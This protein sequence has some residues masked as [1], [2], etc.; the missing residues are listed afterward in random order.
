MTVFGRLSLSKKFL[1]GFGSIIILLVG[2]GSVGVWG[3]AQQSSASSR[4]TRLVPNVR[5]AM[6]AKYQ[7]ADFFGY[8]TAAAYEIA[9]NVPGAIKP[10]APNR[11]AFIKSRSGFDRDLAELSRLDLTRSERATIAT[12]R[13][14]LA[15]FNALDRRGI[16][17]FQAGGSANVAAATKVFLYTEIG[18]YSKMGGA[19]DRLV[20][21]LNTRADAAGH[22]SAST[23]SL[24]STVLIA[25][26]IV[27]ALLGAGIAVVLS[28]YLLRA[29]ARLAAGLRQ[30]DA[31]DLSQLTEGL[32]AVADGDLT[33]T[34]SSSATRLPARSADELGQLESTFND[35]LAKATHGVQSYNTMRG[36]LAEMIGEITRGS[37]TVSAASQ[38]MASTSEETSRA[39]GEIASAV[40]NVAH[41]AEQQVKLV[42]QTREVTDASG[43]AAER[44]NEVAEQ[45][46]ATVEKA[47]Q[48]MGAVRES[49]AAIADTIHTLAGK[50][51]QI[52]GIVQTITTISEQTNLLALNAAIEAA[53]AGE[54]GR[55]FAVVA[56]EVRK[57][58]EE[59]Q[60]AAATIASIIHEIQD[61]TEKAVSVVEEGNRRT[62][63]GAAVVGEARSAFEAIGGSVEEIRA[64]I[65]AIIG[66]AGEVAS[67]AESSSASTEEVSA[68][69]EETS[70]SAQ[71]IAAS[72]QELANTAEGLQTLVSQ[73]RTA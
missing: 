52:G 16:A 34:A 21:S 70:A 66:A 24:V 14:G 71:Q 65:D 26:V 29:V 27:G 72:A 41:G 12:A 23:A 15:Q 10:T 42:E 9:R 58:A 45:G 32:Q 20:R 48:A 19:M 39:V 60:Q 3:S 28:R 2:V 7:T 8:Q 18:P 46:V 36:R 35:M 69:T 63:E 22:E 5:L 30:L 56:E 44:A 53:R 11:A 40:S 61:E 25:L 51:D 17:L 33:R 57:L 49:S 13:A 64:K 43:A 31:D 50:S 54:Q 1:C 6:Q 47:D 68:A 73:F 37:Q 59:S 62:E 38:E 4:V 55:G 67:V